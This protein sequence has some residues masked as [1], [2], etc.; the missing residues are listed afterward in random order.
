[1]RTLLPFLLAVLAH[2]AHAEGDI[3]VVYGDD[4]AHRGELSTELAARWSQTSR[5]GQ[6]AGK[7]LWQGVAEFGYGLSDTLNVGI[8]IPVAH[9]D[10]TWHA[11]GAYAEVKYVAPHGP[12]GWYW[13]A[14]IE[15]GSIKAIGEERAFVLEA[16]PILGYRTGRL[17]LTAN[18]GLEYS[19][20]GEDRGWGFAPKVKVAYS[21]ND[22]HAVGLE[23]HLDAGKLGEFTPRRQR[24]ETAYLTWDARFA[25]HAVNLA[26]GHGAT[27]RS[28]RWA[29]RLGVELDD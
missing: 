4:L 25:G 7:P 19:S 23:Y 28:D 3:D 17:H 22:S 16:F 14:E 20:E 9:I 15:A 29:L 18:P 11:S 5:S 1:M 10:G 13:G 6:F 12:A 24:A 26:L 27:R 2:S 21:I 8:K